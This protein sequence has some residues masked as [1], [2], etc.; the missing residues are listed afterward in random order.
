M[1]EKTK[2]ILIYVGLLLIAIMAVVFR[3]SSA[4]FDNEV[5]RNIYDQQI[6]DSQQKHA[7]YLNH[8]DLPKYIFEG[9]VMTDPENKK[10]YQ[11]YEIQVTKVSTMSSMD[12]SVE[13][14]E[15]NESD[16]TVLIKKINVATEKILEKTKLLVKDKSSEPRM[17]GD[18]LQFSAKISKPDIIEGKDGRSFDYEH[19]LQKDDIFY[20]AEIS[21]VKNLA[22]NQ[23]GKL[24]GVL[25]KIKR[26]FMKNIE[27]LLP[28][29]H[30]FLATGLVISGK[31]SLDKELQDQFQK[32]GLI[33]IVVLSGF[34]VSI[35][36][37][38][39]SKVF[40][41]LPKIWG[42]VF[43]SIGIVFFGMMTGGGA[44]VWR[45]VIMSIIGIYARISKRNNSAFISLM[46]AGI[47]MLIQNPKLFFHDPSFQLSFV[48]T[49]GLIFLASPIEAFLQWL[50]K[51]VQSF[52]PIFLMSLKLIPDSLISLVSTTIATQIFTLPFIIDFSGVISVVA[53]PVNTIV[54]PLIPFTMLFVFLTGAISFIAPVLA[55]L[56][57]FVS[58]ILLSIELIIVRYFSE[59]PFS[60]ITLPPISSSSF[61]ILYFC[62]ILFTIVVNSKSIFARDAQKQSED[63]QKETQVSQENI[64]LKIN[65]TPV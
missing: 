62:I 26:S 35:V 52:S 36:G 13:L 11:K 15:S 40:S 42:G 22:K 47:C 61:I 12:K 64:W 29:P 17:Y 32:V 34:N 27:N 37:E 51:T 8:L 43:G 50:K 41:F 10:T 60:I 54:L 9:K 58:W 3:Y 30:A 55:Y 24:T 4:V 39:I 25:Y 45:S 53:L 6:S 65:T 18:L 1:S 21:D 44:T 33:H 16:E 14:N 57:A 31:G 46:I 2:R 5:L 48:A 19:F 63:T 23:A 20:L 7:G 38:A 56:P 49:L 59:L 28:S